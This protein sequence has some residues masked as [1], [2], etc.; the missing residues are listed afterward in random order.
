MTHVKRLTK[1][2][3]LASTITKLADG[4]PDAAKIIADILLGADRNAGVLASLFA[5][6]A[7]QQLDVLG[8]YGDRFVKLHAKV[9]RGNA[10]KTAAVLDCFHSKILT[11]E[12]V[13]DAVDGDG[14]IDLQAA[15]EALEDKT[16]GFHAGYR[17]EIFAR[18]A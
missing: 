3:G 9:S 12:Q 18:A 10:A 4:N 2:D 5:L 11:A 1:E 6:T 8:I 7:I 14:T 16:R 13:V 17:S 15:M